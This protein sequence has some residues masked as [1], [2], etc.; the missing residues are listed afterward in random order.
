MNYGEEL[1]YWYLRLNGFF[2]LIDFVIHK[3]NQFKYRSDIDIIAIRPPHVFEEVGG[4]KPDWDERLT[5]CFDFNQYVG[6]ICEVKTGGFDQARLFCDKNTKAGVQ[7]SGLFPKNKIKLVIDD[8]QKGA[9]Y[10][11][12]SKYTFVKLLI[13]TGHK[14]KNKYISLSV[15]EIEKFILD[16]IE[17]YANEKYASRM[18]FP[19]TMFQLLIAQ[20]NRKRSQ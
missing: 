14:G 4:K 9:G 2:P 10:P 20:N 15:K 6:L 17:K 5:D 19:S 16:R 3:S 18:F 11:S 7:R 13:S 12:N 8:L 1:A